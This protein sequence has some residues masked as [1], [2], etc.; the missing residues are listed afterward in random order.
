MF[1]IYIKIMVNVWAIGDVTEIE[2]LKL[3][4]ALQTSYCQTD[5][6]WWQFCSLSVEK[7]LLSILANIFS[8]YVCQVES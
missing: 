2:G 5:F 4:L 6:S 1:T 3:N 7:F 8:L